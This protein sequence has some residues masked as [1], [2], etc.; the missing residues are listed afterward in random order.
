MSDIEDYKDKIEK[1]ETDIDGYQNDIEYYKFEIE[2][3]YKPKIKELEDKIS[4]FVIGSEIEERNSVLRKCRSLL[5]SVELQDEFKDN[6]TI[7]EIINDLIEEIE[8]ASGLK[9]K[10]EKLQKE[11]AQL[12]EELDKIK[13]EI[14]AIEKGW[15]AD[16]R[17]KDKGSI[18]ED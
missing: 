7:I 8:E 12:S 11:E 5:M 18:F 1:Y 17:R 9:A 4:S 13:T 3:T 16:E 6:Q 2:E 10:K 15:E 14:E